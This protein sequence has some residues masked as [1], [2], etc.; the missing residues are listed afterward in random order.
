MGDY[1]GVRFTAS[2]NQIGRKV[3][4]LMTAPL[5]QAG[6]DTEWATWED[7]QQ[8]YPKLKLEEFLTYSRSYHIPRGAL[9]FQPRD[10]EWANTYNETEGTWTVCCSF[11]DDEQQSMTKCFIYRVLLNLVEGI[12]TV[13]V[14]PPDSRGPQKHLIDGTPLGRG[15]PFGD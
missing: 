8:R 6:D 12:T 14:C 10:W 4:S 13:E 1:T 5:I 2:L 7:V 9:Q 15:L 3:A 11:K